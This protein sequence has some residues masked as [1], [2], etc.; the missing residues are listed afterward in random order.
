MHINMQ[1][2]YLCEHEQPKHT[3]EDKVNRNTY[4]KIYK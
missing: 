4:I 1:P 2:V 3:I